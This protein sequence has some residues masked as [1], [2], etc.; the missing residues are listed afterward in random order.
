MLSGGELIQFETDADRLT[1]P[2]FG[3]ITEI[4]VKFTTCRASAR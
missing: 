3:D 2:V 4:Q 1:G